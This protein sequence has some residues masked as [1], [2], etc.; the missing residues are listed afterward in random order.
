MT[1]VQPT[2]GEVLEAPPGMTADDLLRLPDDGYKYELYEGMLVREM[3]SPGHGEICQ[4]LG[5]VLFVYSQTTGF[6]N[7]TVQNGLFNFSPQGTPD[8]IVLA[9]DVAI[10]RANAVAPWQVPH[11]IPMIAAE[12]VSDSQT[13]SEIALKTQTYLAA[14]VEEVWVIDHKSRTVEVWTTQG[15]NTLDEKATLTSALLPGFSVAVR[16]LLDG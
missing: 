4:R 7:R 8:R 14:G 5:G 1:S 3:T 9:P 10:M 2:W 16:F 12:V 6:Q 11:E 13:K 15:T